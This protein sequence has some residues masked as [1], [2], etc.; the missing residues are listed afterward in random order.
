MCMQARQTANW[1]RIVCFMA[2]GASHR[3]NSIRVSAL[4]CTGEVGVESLCECP[5]SSPQPPARRVRSVFSRFA[6]TVLCQSHPQLGFERE[7]L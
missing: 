3:P 2:F 1:K 6:V 7:G 4:V 5:S